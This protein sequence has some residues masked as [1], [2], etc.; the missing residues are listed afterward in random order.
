M[1]AQCR[2][3]G[4]T[5]IELLLAL[6]I[7]GLTYGLAAPYFARA[8]PAMGLGQAE[9]ALVSA[10]REARG[11]AAAGGK[12]VRFALTGDGRG[13]RIGGGVATQAPGG[14]ALTLMGAP[15]ARRGGA[16]AI[17]FFPGG[18]ATGGRVSLSAGTRRAA[19]TVD[20]VSGRVRAAR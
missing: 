6:A 13:W 19:V 10:L 17:V 5:L 9:R 12:P 11:A 2:V 15:A 1:A 20:W 8:L 7:L 16:D 4:F 14:V 18:G 3:A